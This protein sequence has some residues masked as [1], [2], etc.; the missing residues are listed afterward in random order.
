[1]NVGA[2]AAGT[3]H[4][5]AEA[6]RHGFAG[7]T[8]AGSIH[9]EQYWGFLC[10]LFGHGWVAHGGLSLYFLK[11]TTGGEAVRCSAVRNDDEAEV[12]MENRAGE[13]IS[14]GTADV[15]RDPDDPRPTAFARRLAA[16]RPCTAPTL[17]AGV[18]LGRRVDAVAG[19][20]AGSEVHA[21]R[22]IV[23]EPLPGYAEE[24]PILPADLAI[25]LMRVVEPHLV[26]VPSGVVGLY[27]AIELRT[28]GEALRAD[29]EYNLSGQVLATGETPRTETLWYRS[30]AMR[31]GKP[32]ARM[33]HMARLLRS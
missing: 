15:G 2:G 28:F 27:G 6:R 7:G 17:L 10:D 21:R 14:E 20:G 33:L 29:T 22:A 4:D 3:I 26:T 25:N 18:E 12:W 23:T 5:D 30:D 16:L 11:P 24:P 19:R 9:M 31:N 8:V 13:R 32:V 1:V